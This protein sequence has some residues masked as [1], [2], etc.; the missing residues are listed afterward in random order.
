MYSQTL[1]H[2]DDAEGAK[3]KRTCGIYK[4]KN[5]HIDDIFKGKHWQT[6][7]DIYK[8]R[9]VYV[10]YVGEFEE[11]LKCKGVRKSHLTDIVCEGFEESRAVAGSWS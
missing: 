5:M 6:L 7:S 10:V 3:Q 4:A 2:L 11:E 8:A 1:K 9:C